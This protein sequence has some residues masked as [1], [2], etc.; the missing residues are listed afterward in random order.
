MARGTPAARQG[1]RHPPGPAGGAGRV[2]P[3]GP[4]G[5]TA[6]GGGPSPPVPAGLS[7]VAAGRDGGGGHAERG[8][9]PLQARSALLR[10]ERLKCSWHARPGE[11]Q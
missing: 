6:A 1:P 2:A 4:R 11:M 8:T 10:R 7:P 3:T 5:R 9:V